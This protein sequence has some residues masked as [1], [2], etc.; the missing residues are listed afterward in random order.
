MKMTGAVLFVIS[1]LLGMKSPFFFLGS[2]VGLLLFLQGME[3]C[4][5]ATTTEYVRRA[6]TENKT[7]DELE[8]ERLYKEDERLHKEAGGE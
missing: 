1:G 5:I 2:A 4:I 8:R 7:F 6:I 3:N